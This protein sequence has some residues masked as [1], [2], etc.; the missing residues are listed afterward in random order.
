M[1]SVKLI[2]SHST[3]TPILSIPLNGFR[4]PITDNRPSTMGENLSIPLNGFIAEKMG[5]V[6][7]NTFN[8]IEWI[9]AGTTGR[10]SYPFTVATFNSIE[11]I[12]NV[13]E[14]VMKDL[15]NM[16]SIPLYGFIQ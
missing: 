1:D 8:S 4:K 14:N 9:P 16:L 10:R 6:S 15:E 7:I 13:P 5:E 12:Q 2:L 11:W 3:L